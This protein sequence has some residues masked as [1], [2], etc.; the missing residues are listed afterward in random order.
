MRNFLFFLSIYV[1]LIS[2]SCTSVKRKADLLI[3]NGVV[4]S[5]N[6]VFSRV[7]AVAVKNHKIVATGSS[8]EILAAYESDSVID[9]GGLFVYPGF[10]DPHSHFYGYAVGLQYVDLT[11]SNSF[12]ELLD[13]IAK[14]TYEPGEWIVG[15]GWDQ[16]LW[17][18]KV[19]PDNSRLNQLYPNNPVMLIRIDGHV[20]LAS[21]KALELAGIK[22]T[23]GFGPGE[24]HME[25]GKLTG[26][27]SE[28]A[29][30]RMR[31]AVPQPDGDQLT[32][33]LREAQRNCFGVGLTSVCDAGLDYRQ[34]ILLDSLQR[35]GILDIHLYVMLT[36]NRENIEK[37]VMKGGIRND[38]MIARSIKIYADGSLGSRT[39]RLKMPYSDAHN[40]LGLVV[41]GPDSVSALCKLAYE[42]DFQVNT[43]C[44]GDAA[45]EMVLKVYSG[46]LKGKNDRR[47][48]VEHAQVVDPADLHYFGDFSIIPSVQSTHATSDMNW[49][50]ERLGPDR[51]RNAYAYRSLMVQNGWLPNGTDFPIENISPLYTFYAAVARRDL[52]GLP[53]GGFQP[54]NALT[55]EEALRSITIWAARAGFSEIQKGSIEPGKDADFTILE[56]DLMSAPDSLLSR[57]QVKHVISRGKVIF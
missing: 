49:A 50:D 27:L 5:V 54:E 18:D 2:N 57:I 20:V 7:E 17:A 21:D 10:M 4:Y 36:P 52:Q 3:V 53:E 44:I 12:D 30:D 45:N 32:T 40:H 55:R 51:I 35:S 26:I 23:T 29:A 9:A 15:R 39:A 16:N 43:H 11:G 25:K 19:F 24:I 6:A 13:R 46:F 31:S 8:S 28:T 41:T 22:G 38:M 14:K 42:N 56:Q 34:V 1:G 33:L 37:L 47:W 48:R